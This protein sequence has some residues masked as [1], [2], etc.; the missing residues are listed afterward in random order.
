MADGP[1]IQAANLR[2][3]TAG[4]TTADILSLAR[5]FRARHR[6]VPLV[7]MGYAN[8]MVRRGPEWFAAQCKDAG[9]DGV[10][11]GLDILALAG[12]KTVALE[13]GLDRNDGRVIAAQA[14][15]VGAGQRA[16]AHGGVNA[17]FEVRPAVGGRLVAADV[18]A[19]AAVLERRGEGVVAGGQVLTLLGREAP[20]LAV[21][22]LQLHQSVIVRANSIGGPGR[23]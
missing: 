4:T 23:Q 12:A 13:A 10:E 8:P 22:G 17:S 1:A 2:S 18:V 16:G 9:V 5:D 15:G 11:A 7:L 19:V 21:A 3:L 6:Q 14:R 20:V